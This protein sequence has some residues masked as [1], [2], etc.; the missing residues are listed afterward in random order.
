[1]KAKQRPFVPAVF[2]PLALLAA[3]QTGSREPQRAEAPLPAEISR[4]LETVRSERTDFPEFSEIPAPPAGV[5][6]VE[7]WREFVVSTQGQ[8]TALARWV[9][10]NPPENTD[11]PGYLARARAALDNAGDPPSADQRVQTEAWAQRMRQAAVPPPPP[12]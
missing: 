6:T 7:Q 9:A 1:M 4:R 11:L 12:Q 3:C 5:R 2:L 8:G 10:A